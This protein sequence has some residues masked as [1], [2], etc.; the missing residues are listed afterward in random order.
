MDLILTLLGGAFVLIAVIAAAGMF[1]GRDGAG[2]SFAGASFLAAICLFFGLSYTLGANEVGLEITRGVINEE[3]VG[4]GGLHAKGP[5]TKVEKFSILPYT[6]GDVD[7]QMTNLDGGTFGLRVT[8]RW[9][10]SED[11]VVDLFKS[12][13]TSDESE[14]EEKILR[15]LLSGHANDVAKQYSNSTVYTPDGKAIVS[16]GVPTMSTLD[17]TKKV[18]DLVA[19]QLLESGIVL[20]SLTPTGKVSVSEQMQQAINENAASREKTK[21]ATQDVLTAKQEA[22]AAKERANG[23]RDAATALPA[24]LTPEQVQVLCMQAWQTEMKRATEKGVPVY[25]VPCGAAST[26]TLVSAGAPR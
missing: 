19:P 23:A 22:L 18:F 5:L 3:P 8:P 9:H 1:K 20:D 14:I 7:L 6:G 13:R 25:T 2:S 26:G 16:E 10:A 17:F 12:R 4:P 15:P 24:S 21:N 11:K